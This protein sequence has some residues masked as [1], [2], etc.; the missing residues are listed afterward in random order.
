MTKSGLAVDTDLR[1]LFEQPQVSRD[2]IIEAFQ[3]TLGALPDRGS[4]F[5]IHLSELCPVACLH[6]M[7]SSDLRR[8]SFKDSLTESELD[9]AIAFI[10]DSRSEKLNITGGGEP[11]LKFRSILRLLER[12]NVPRVE[13]VTAGYWAKSEQRAAR[14]LSQMNEA[15]SRNPHGPEALL[16]LSLDRYH[17]NAPRPVRIEH[18][19][20]VV[21]AWQRSPVRLGLGFRSIQPDMDTVDRQL[22]DEVG[23]EV[24]VVNDWNRRIVL[25]DGRGLP[26][27]FNVFRL[28]G[29]AAELHDDLLEGT[30]TIKEYY[31]PFESGSNKLTLATAVNDAIRGSYT[32][33][34]GVA[35]T[36]NSDGTFWIFCGTSPD[37]RLLFDSQRFSD[38]LAYF[39]ED[40]ITHL[41]IRDG[42]W[43]LADL[44]SRLD[45]A[46]HL[47]AVA[48]NDVAFLVE[49]LLAPADVR[50]A[51]TLRA[52][53]G[54]VADGSAVTQG[55]PLLADILRSDDLLTSCTALIREG[56]S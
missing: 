13:I 37:R 26:I 51:V 36:M 41:L 42:V 47:T 56:R 40:P 53:A 6:C 8:K 4:S 29:K 48:K 28:S 31:S 1:T 49:D 44:V 18:Y 25:P 2:R 55:D 32:A 39:F 5:F 43:Y 19:G 54:M 21:R 46:T 10:N 9:Q 12:V 50:L 14:L 15:L 35:V 33:S 20:N 16:R 45:P 23:A 52:T 30:Q 24:D 7:Y 22:A 17:I 38:A 11:F 34:P 27:T 3:P